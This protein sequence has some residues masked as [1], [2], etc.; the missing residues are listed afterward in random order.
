MLILPQSYLYLRKII[1]FIH[2]NSVAGKLGEPKTWPPEIT[3]PPTPAPKPTEP[4]SCKDKASK[5]QCDYWA[6]MGYCTS[7]T[8]AIKRMAQD[9]CCATCKGNFY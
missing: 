7:K 1:K 3:Y 9:Q 4:G 6:R 5:S 2:L 8:A